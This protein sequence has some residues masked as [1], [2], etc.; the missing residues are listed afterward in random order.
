MTF[1]EYRISTAVRRGSAG[2]PT[3]K[4]IK[5]YDATGRLTKQQFFREY[6]VHRY[7]FDF[8]AKLLEDAEEIREFFMVVFFGAGG[9]YDGFRV[10]D[11]NDYEL[12]QANSS[13]TLVSGAVWQINRVYR[14]GAVQFV[15]PIYKT[16]AGTV[17][18]Y[19]TRSSLVTVASAT[20]DENLGRATISGHVGGDTYTAERETST[21]L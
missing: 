12:T 6:P 20:I 11:W 1:L 15:R 18:V 13:L 5:L 9:P 19:R 14:V 8:G 7:S 2:G 3:A 10:R 21:C 17:V 4:R 16:E